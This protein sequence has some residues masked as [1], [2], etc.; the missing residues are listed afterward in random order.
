MN[1]PDVFHTGTAVTSAS[2]LNETSLFHA[3]LSTTTVGHPLWAKVPSWKRGSSTIHQGT[4]E[5]SHPPVHQEIGI[6]TLVPDVDLVATHEQ[7]LALLG[8]S[9]GTL[10]NTVIDK[11]LCT[12]APLWKSRFP[13][14]ESQH[15]TGAK[16]YICVWMY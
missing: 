7:V 11:H 1:G 4:Q 3:P 15:T 16:R 12:R 14:E 13:V 8:H 5:E 6:Q 2:Q 9:L 10:E